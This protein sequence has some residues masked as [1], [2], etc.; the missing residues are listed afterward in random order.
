MA[1]FLYDVTLIE[2]NEGKATTPQHRDQRVLAFC[3]VIADSPAEA[4]QQASESFRGLEYT[5]D[6]NTTYRYQLVAVALAPVP[7]LTRKV[8]T[9]TAQEV[10]QVT[11]H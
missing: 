8:I 1:M 3:R 5:N 10:I 7:D 11:R 2:V 6:D 4:A 9:P